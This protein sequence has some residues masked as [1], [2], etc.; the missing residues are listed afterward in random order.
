MATVDQSIKVDRN[1]IQRRWDALKNE[2]S[3][4][5]DHWR[6][7]SEYVM[8]RT[9]RFFITDRNRGDKRINKIYDNTATRSLRILGAGMMSGNTSPARPWI[10]L[11]TDDPD[12][13]K[14]APVKAWLSDVTALQ[15][16]IFHKSNTYRMLHQAYEELGLYGTSASVQMNDFKNVIHH[17]PLT[18]GEYAIAVNERNEV[19][20]LYRELQ[21]R[22]GAVVREFG[23][24]NCSDTIKAMHRSGN[25][26][27]WVTVVH[28][29][30]P[31]V[32]RDPNSLIAANKAFASIYFEPGTSQDKFLRV[33]GFDRFR[34]LCPRWAATGGDIYGSSP[35]MDV[36]GDVKQLQHEQLRKAQGIDYKTNPPLQVPIS[37]QHSQ[38]DRLPGGVTFVDDTSPGRGIR[39]AFDVNLDLS[40]LLADIGD[41]RQRINSGFYADLFLMLANSTDQ[42]K[43][44]T[45]VAELHEEKM[46]MLGPVL[47][48]LNNELLTPLVENT[49]A[50]CVEVGILPPPPKELQGRPLSIE[51][52]SV[53]AQ[54]QRAIGAGSTDRFVNSI[55]A[56]AGFKPEVLDKFDAD[57]WAEAYADTLGID[58]RLIVPGD[59][60]ALIRQARTEEAMRQ[61][62]MAAL[63]QGAGAARDLA[64][65]SQQIDAAPNVLSQFTGYN[66]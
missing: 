52:I 4:W 65:A 15:L 37:M 39:S 32:E 36:L 59:K 51:F 9:G 25:L 57:E 21:M 60:V 33:S 35:G 14:Y 42:S 40:H 29:I 46:L 44:A 66:S 64:S 49:F 56:V 27:S 50:R 16:R 43:T 17:H 38:L 45:E 61:Q 54:A 24:E 1:N 7:L 58:P 8:P 18:I 6:E 11:Q 13:N 47:E 22:V 30:E 12:L 26:D 55:G 10:R 31:R 34:A 28:A 2:R 23:L 63:Q 5:F 48:R 19:D 41:I 53:L 20:T 3:T 62:Q